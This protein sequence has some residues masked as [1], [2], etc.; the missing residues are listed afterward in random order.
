MSGALGAHR[1]RT[2]PPTFSI[3]EPLFGQDLVVSPCGDR[4]D[5][6]ELELLCHIRTRHP[7]AADRSAS[8]SSSSISA[9]SVNR[10]PTLTSLWQCVAEGSGRI[11]RRRCQAARNLS[12]WATGHRR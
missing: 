4:A 1:V 9:R 12:F 3:G 10:Y 6:T 5:A 7:E 2:T 11:G 8:P